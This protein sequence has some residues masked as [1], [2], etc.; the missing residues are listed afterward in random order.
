M[1]LRNLSSL[2]KYRNL[3]AQS[4]V[5]CS[6][7]TGSEMPLDRSRDLIGPKYPGNSNVRQI[8]FKRN[9]NESEIEQ[10]YREFR[11][12]TEQWHV[13]Y[14]ERHNSEFMNA[15]KVY[16]AETVLEKQKNLAN[17]ESDETELTAE[18]MSMFYKNYLLQT[19]ARHLAYN[20]EWYKRNFYIVYMSML[21][22]ISQVREKLRF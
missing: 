3:F 17:S 5:K 10:R 4:C 21:V 18:E 8:L 12:Q 20:K 14:W 6:N 11:E 22:K 2:R 9:A 13:N 15:K 7:K 19:R 16:I 1:S